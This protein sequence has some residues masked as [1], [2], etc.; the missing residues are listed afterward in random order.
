MRVVSN[1]SLDN[2]NLGDSYNSD[3]VK[4]NNSLVSLVATNEVELLREPAK[5]ESARSMRL[6]L[7]I[8]TR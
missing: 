7:W 2:S 3:L 5:K 8:L 1:S 6:R 4:G